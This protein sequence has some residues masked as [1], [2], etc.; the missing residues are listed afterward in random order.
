MTARAP[1]FQPLLFRLELRRALGGG[2]AP[3]ALAL[4]VVLVLAPWSTPDIVTIE[5]RAAA[6]ARG[7]QRQG[8][9]TGALLF[10]VPALVWRAAG[11]LARWRRGDADWLGSRPTGKLA[12]LVST[13]AG[14][15]AAGALLLAAVALFIELDVDGDAATFAYAGTSGLADVRRIEP[16][17]AR[18]FRMPDPGARAPAGSRV[19]ARVT[20]TVGAGPTTVARLTVR[21]TAGDGGEQT[22]TAR[23]VARTWIEVELPPGPGALELELASEGAG[24]LAVLAPDSFQLWIP[25]GDER[26]ASLTI[27]IRSALGLAA[28]LALAMG[29]GAWVS[30]VTAG[31]GALL[32]WPALAIPLGAPGW[33][34]A[35]RLARALAFVG[36]GRLPEALDPRALLGLLA[37]VGTGLALALPGLRSW[38]HG[39]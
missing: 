38:R 39:R 8:I 24:A 12:A 29:F 23:V 18:T 21:R 9:W 7:L 25:G 14:T 16:G 26:R 31:L 37:C 20:V 34:P 28:G 33:L 5:P 1:L 17:T 30:P 6:V 13:W 11:T 19:R 22:T 35:A 32:L 27:F 10:L 15:V 3:F 4:L 2:F 36:E